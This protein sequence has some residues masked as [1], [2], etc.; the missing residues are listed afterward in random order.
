MDS[1]EQEVLKLNA[2]GMATR[3]I[4]EAL[5][6]SQREVEWI[7]ARRRPGMDLTDQEREA[8]KLAADEEVT[9]IRRAMFKLLRKRGVIPDELDD[10][11]SEGRHTIPP[12]EK[13]DASPLPFSPDSRPRRSL[14]RF[15]DVF[16]D[17]QDE[18]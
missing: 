11:T 13:P 17:D 16:K 8:V 2:D 5:Q 12:P 1:T 14:G 9:A 6:L 4:A 7:L 3:E 10:A 15:E 18:E